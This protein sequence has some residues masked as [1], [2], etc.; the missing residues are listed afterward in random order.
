MAGE[1]LL[2]FVEA[3]GKLSEII[4]QVN[5]RGQAVIIAKRR[6]PVAVVLGVDRY[7]QMVNAGKNVRKVKGKRLLRLRALASAVGNIDRAVADLRR[8]R[9]EALL[10]SA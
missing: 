10:K 6:K 2:S 1:K 4:D 9:L 5:Q 7:R 8:S 3:R